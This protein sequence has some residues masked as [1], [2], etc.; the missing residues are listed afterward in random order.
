MQIKNLWMISFAMKAIETTRA[1]LDQAQEKELE[2]VFASIGFSTLR[3]IIAAHCT[4]A[5]AAYASATLYNT[6]VA[7]DVATGEKDKA[8][9][10]NAALEILDL[11]QQRKEEW[12]RVNI[13]PR[14]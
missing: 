11:I 9:R 10:Y 1:Y 4:E 13:E 2:K 3:E 5:I 7:I 14:R 12:Y 8:I 6:E